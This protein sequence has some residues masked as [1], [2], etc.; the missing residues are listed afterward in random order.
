VKKLQKPRRI[1]KLHKLKTKLKKSLFRPLKFSRWTL[2][3]LAAIFLLLLLFTALNFFI[4]INL[5]HNLQKDF[6]SFQKNTNDQI[7]ALSLAKGESATEAIN[8][9][10]DHF[11]GLSYIDRDKTNMNW[12]ENVTA[13]TFPPIY[14][15][16][17]TDDASYSSSEILSPDNN[18]QAINNSLYY[19]GKKLKLP[20]EF[21]S[22]N[23]LNLSVGL[24]GNRSLVG[25]VTGKNYDERGWV[26]SFDPRYQSF[27]PLITDTTSERIEIR[28]G[29]TGGTIA[30][31]G[32]DD[33]FLIVYG[34]YNG[35]VLYYY[36]GA[37]SDVSRFFGLRVSAEGFSPQILSRDNSRGTIFYVCSKTEGKPKLIKFWPKRA[38]ELMGSLDFSPLIFKADLAAETASC[39]LEGADVLVDMGEAGLWRFTDGGFDNSLDRQAVSLDLGMNRGRKISSAVAAE[40]DLATDG[41]KQNGEQN[42][43]AELFMA[44]AAD[45]WQK[46]EPFIWWKFPEPTTSL[47]WKMTFKAEPGYPDYSPWFDD[48]NQLNYRTF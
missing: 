47:F 28:Y 29:R 23:I 19:R 24:A 14:T 10:G 44:N 3:I 18:L 26:Y 25:I 41:V 37:L 16:T 6:S 7:K 11:S 5:N 8:S 21:N 33:N 45:K 36:Q 38:G 17:K 46:V 30:F 2:I 40:I 15:F 22:E 39:R 13:F 20:P 4:L 31:G 35:H 9:F 43:R 1:N 32:T 12:D 48:I 42:S 27:S 34:G